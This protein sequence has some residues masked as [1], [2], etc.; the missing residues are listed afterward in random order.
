MK[1]LITLAAV[2]SLAFTTFN[3]AAISAKYRAQL[4]R[5]GCTQMTDG[6][7]CDIHKTKA[8]NA[9]AAKKT[10]SNVAPWAGK[11]GAFK[12]NGQ[13]VADIVITRANTVTINGKKGAKVYISDEALYLMPTPQTTYTF[14][15]LR[16]VDGKYA[17]NWAGTEGMGKIEKQ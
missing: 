9:A 4:E 13:R 7:G 3:A 12:E 5:S 1:K 10:A 8:Q 11:Y 14:F 16:R 15:P 2:I 6:N 17:G